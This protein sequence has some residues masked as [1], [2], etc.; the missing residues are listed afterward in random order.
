LGREIDAAVGAGQ[1]V[2]VRDV[3]RLHIEAY[4]AGS[5]VSDGQRFFAIAGKGS[6]QAMAD[7]LRDMYPERASVIPK[8]EPGCDYM[9]VEGKDGEPWEVTY[10][11]E[12]L[13]YIATKAEKVFGIKWIGF[14]QSLRDTAEALKVFL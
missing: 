14:R 11:E 12:Q 6:P 8:G 5:A 2:D 10:T 9:R 3:A 1:F 13:R 7:V 4:E